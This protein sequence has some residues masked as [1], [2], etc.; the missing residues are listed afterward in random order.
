MDR[1]VPSGEQPLAVLRPAQIT[2]TDPYA[3]E[4]EIQDTGLMAQLLGRPMHHREAWAVLRA[5]YQDNTLAV[6]VLRLQ[7]VAAGISLV[8]TAQRL[9]SVILT[10][11]SSGSRLRGFIDAP[12][13]ATVWM[14]DARWE[15]ST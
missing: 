15:I 6:E 11:S 8:V 3:V 10:V 7:S 9:P 1:S 5:T 13:D 2:G 14:D 12:D 4:A